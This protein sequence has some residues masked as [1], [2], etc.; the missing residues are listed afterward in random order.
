MR[1]LSVVLLLAVAALMAGPS[2]LAAPPDH[3]RVP[4]DDL[5]TTDSCGFPVEVHITGFAVIHVRESKD[6]S[7]HFFSAGPQ[8]KATLT[9]L[10]TG[11][12]ITVNIAGPVHQTDNPDGSFTFVGTGTWLRSAH[13]ET[14]EPG[15]FRSAG[16][17]GVI[18]DTEGNET[19][20]EH[21]RLTDLCPKLAP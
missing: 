3:E 13:P 5:F 10:D 8:I 7:V 2:A 4:V 16:R 11:E 9:N 17:F 12:S 18:V 20:F 21:G 14:H 6:G 15:L 1:R 19:F